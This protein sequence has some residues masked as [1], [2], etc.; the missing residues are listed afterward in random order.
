VAEH[1]GS[2][3]ERDAEA[4]GETPEP[5]SGESTHFNLSDQR[6]ELP[7]VG[8]ERT[9]RARRRVRAGH[10]VQGSRAALMGWRPGPNS[11]NASP[12]GDAYACL[13]IRGVMNA[14]LKARDAAYLC[15]KVRGA[16]G[17]CLG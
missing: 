9:L 15:L 17:R 14:C 3:Y 10:G 12:I 8:L 7:G 16:T 6:F 11:L 4:R 1:Q 2:R 13:K 5:G